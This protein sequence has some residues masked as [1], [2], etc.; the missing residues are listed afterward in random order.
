M[1]IHERTY[2]L[3]GAGLVGVALFSTCGS[4]PRNAKP[5][6]HFELNRYLGKWYEIARFDYRFEKNLNNVT[7]KYSLND[8]GTVRVVNS[9]FDYKKNEWKSATGKA[10]FRNDKQT[11]ALKVSFFGPFYSGYNVIAIDKDYQYALVAGESL[12]YL[13]ILS[14]TTTIPSDVKQAY[15]EKAKAVG[16]DTSKLIWV[17]HDKEN[18]Y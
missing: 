1:K 5:I 10:K 4:I 15:L 17:E 16:Y 11:A 7:A 12:K 9:G 14:R 13:W 2:W 8:N 6:D 18:P 3:L